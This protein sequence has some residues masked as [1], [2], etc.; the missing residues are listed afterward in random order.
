MKIPLLIALLA[1]ATYFY[2]HNPASTTPAGRIVDAR[3]SNAVTAPAVI[4][5]AAPASYERWKTG[6]NAQTD[7]KTGPNAQTDFQ[8]FASN[9]HTTWNQTPGYTIMSGR[10]VSGRKVSRRMLR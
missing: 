3:S 9:E 1:G 6:P 7:L 8:P 2:F 5:A 10:Q 4:I